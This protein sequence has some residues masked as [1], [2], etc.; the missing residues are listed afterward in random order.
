MQMSINKLFLIL[1]EIKYNNTLK[2]NNST[3]CHTA[4][5][6]IIKQQRRRYS[7][8]NYYNSCQPCNKNRKHNKYVKL[9]YTLIVVEVEYRIKPIYLYNLQ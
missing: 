1:K 4:V 2:Q 9:L 6:K 5:T 7:S 3:T 8:N